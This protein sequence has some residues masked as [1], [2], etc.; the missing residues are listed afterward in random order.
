MI[1][2][3]EAAGDET[4][5]KFTHRFEVLWRKV[6]GNAYHLLQA[7]RERERRHRE[8]CAVTA[9]R[10]LL[11]LV[12]RATDDEL[13]ALARFLAGVEGTPL[14]H[15]LRGLGQL[16]GQLRGTSGAPAESVRIADFVREIEDAA[17][18]AYNYFFGPSPLTRDPYLVARTLM[19]VFAK[20]ELRGLR[21]LALFTA[22]PE[23]RRFVNK[24]VMTLL[25]FRL[26][27]EH[28][29]L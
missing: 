22:P 28:G 7:P 13:L 29:F 9:L 16:H 8:G 1:M 10:K 26:A 27:I 24:R 2:R 5:E 23:R 6:L 3:R 17:Q 4:H 12:R 21:A 25:F 15:E 14:E 19:E 18:E 11:A 20:M